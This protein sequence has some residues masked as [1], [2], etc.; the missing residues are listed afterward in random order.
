MMQGVGSNIENSINPNIVSQENL[1]Q[2]YQLDK[3]LAQGEVIF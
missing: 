1:Y 3:R 2:K